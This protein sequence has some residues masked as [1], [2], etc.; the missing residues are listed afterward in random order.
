MAEFYQ[1]YGNRK[2]ATDDYPLHD[3]CVIG[4]LLAPAL[5]AGRSCNVTIELVSPEALG[6]TVVDW[7][8]VTPRT[9]NCLVL[10][11]LDSAAFYE[12]MLE[13]FRRLP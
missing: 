1:R 2:F 10:H 3:P 6:R 13:R 5:F 8:G 12:L 4:Y 9:R 11:D 7:W